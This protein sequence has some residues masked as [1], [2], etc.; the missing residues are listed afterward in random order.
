MSKTLW[1]WILMSAAVVLV[2]GYGLLKTMNR[3][4][5]VP[6][7]TPQPERPA[8]STSEIARSN[9]NPLL[10][11]DKA[12]VA[13]WFPGHCFA[14][15]Y[16]KDPSFGGKMIPGCLVKVIEQVKADTGVT[17]TDK[18]VQA[19]EVVAHFKEVYGPS[20]PWRQ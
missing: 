15:L 13:K 14:E 18:E 16:A 12:A 19:P 7:V 20:N 6:T 17:L 8:S 9:E 5:I 3:E 1:T 11:A 2:G 4:P 10:S